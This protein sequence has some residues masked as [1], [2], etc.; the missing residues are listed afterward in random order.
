MREKLASMLIA[1]VLGFA[2]GS[3]PA[4]SCDRERGCDQIARAAIHGRSY[5]P[6][7]FPPFSRDDIRRWRQSPQFK[8]LEH[9]SWFESEFFQAV[10]RSYR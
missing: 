3:T 9:G 4:M 6:A 2:N 5:C 8:L 10:R 1:A 7:P